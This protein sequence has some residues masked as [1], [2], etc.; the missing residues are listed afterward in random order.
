MQKLQDAVVEQLLELFPRQFH[1]MIKIPRC[2]ICH[3]H[4]IADVGDFLH[5]GEIE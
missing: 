1:T 2:M 4:G 3:L 5:V